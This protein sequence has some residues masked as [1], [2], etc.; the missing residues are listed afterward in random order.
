MTLAEFI[1]EERQNS[2]DG[3]MAPIVEGLSKYLAKELKNNEY[4]RIRWEYQKEK[5]EVNDDHAFV[6][7][8]RKVALYGWLIEQG[9][10]YQDSIC[11]LNGQ[12]TGI[13]VFVY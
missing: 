13:R 4:A 9:F 10:R 7:Y 5:E 6:Y 3:V 1:K 2:Q 11:H 12:I 8:K